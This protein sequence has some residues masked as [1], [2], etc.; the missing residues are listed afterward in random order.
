MLIVYITIVIVSREIIAYNYS[1]GY[2]H[3]MNSDIDE[4]T[5][6]AVGQR[7]KDAREKQSM[8]QAEVAESSEI[9]INYYARIERGEEN[10]STKILLAIIKALK[11]K[12]SDILP[13]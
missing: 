7:M 3:V 12:S 1:S 4:K 2:N 13:Y 11:A 9:S 6:K 8:S 10:P 5:M